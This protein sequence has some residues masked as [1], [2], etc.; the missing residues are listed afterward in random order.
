MDTLIRGGYLLGENIVYATSKSLSLLLDLFLQVPL[1]PRFNI[2]SFV[3]ICDSSFFSSWFQLMTFNFAIFL[4]LDH[5]I[6][7]EDIL[8][9]DQGSLVFYFMLRA[10]RE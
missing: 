8:F 9:L 3:L 2:L 7:K 4:N 5:K 1:N 10:G 6:F